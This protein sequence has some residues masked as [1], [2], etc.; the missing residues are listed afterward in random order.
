MSAKAGSAID[1]GAT[2][3]QKWRWPVGP[4]RTL[5]IVSVGLSAVFVL[6]PGLDIWFSRLFYDPAIGFPA[7]N[8]PVF[9][10]LRQLS[11]VLV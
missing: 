4:V 3:P 5:L 1:P 11:E 7:S 9:N 8:V 6:F 10:W 2:S